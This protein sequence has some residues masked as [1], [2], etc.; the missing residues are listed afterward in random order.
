MLAKLKA[1]LGLV[2]ESSFP[3]PESISPKPKH[4]AVIMDGNG[5]WANSRGL[6]RV[7]GHK[8]GVDSVKSVIKSCIKYDIPVLSLFAFSSENWNRSKSEVDALMDLLAD[9]LETQTKKLDENGVRLQLLGDLERFNDRIRSLAKGALAET[10]DN[11]KLVLNVCINYGGR[12]DVLQATKAVAKRVAVGEL[13]VDDIDEETLSAHM[14]TSGLPD[15]DLFIRTSGEYRLSNFMLW[16]AAYAEFHF[17]D[18]L[19]PDFNEEVFAQALI[20][21]TNRDRRYGGAKDKVS[22][23]NSQQKVSLATPLPAEE[24]LDNA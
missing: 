10:S 18:V 3:E 7:S 13:S 16:Q 6:S 9:A 8:R 23:S 5:R 11:T 12:W 20:Q 21:F 4:V 15:P 22:K 24:K 2:G 1:I 17:T 14:S 19:W